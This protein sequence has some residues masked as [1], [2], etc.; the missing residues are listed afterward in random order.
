ML[1][2]AVEE[3]SRVSHGACRRVSEADG[4]V[5]GLP[6]VRGLRFSLGFRV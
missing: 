6:G 2:T 1:W 5:R 3:A 4:L